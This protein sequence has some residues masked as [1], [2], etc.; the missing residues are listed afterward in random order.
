MG[1]SAGS[2]LRSLRK[3]EGGLGFRA[4]RE[5]ILVIASKARSGP[6]PLRLAY[7]ALRGIGPALAEEAL[8]SRGFRAVRD[9]F[10][11]SLPRLALDRS[12]SAGRIWRSAGSVLRSLRK[13]EGGLGFRAV[14][15]GF[16]CS[17]PRLAPDRSRSAGRIW[18]SAGSVLR[19]QEG[20]GK[21]R[22]FALCA[23][24]FGVRFQGSLRTDPAPLGVWG[25]P[26]VVG[27]ISTGLGPG[28][29]GCF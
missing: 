2:V 5:G 8:G 27:K 6:I 19:S 9:G 14:R 29:V 13:L 23:R 3:L 26:R 11:C 12:R 10:W 1:R 4:V 18:R 20:S 24:G 22:A 7:L 15:D 21:D 28:S 25:A 17:L 16:W